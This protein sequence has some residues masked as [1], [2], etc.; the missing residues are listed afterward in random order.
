MGNSNLTE[1]LQLVRDACEADLETYI[2]TIAPH[3]V[4]GDIHK[5][6]ISWW[7]RQDAKDNQL[8]LLPRAHQKS[9]MVA[10][11][12]AWNIVNN[13]SLTVLYVSATADLAEIQLGL[14]KQIFESPV[15]Q[16]LWPDLID[17]DEGKRTRW[18][19]SEII[20]DHPVRKIEAV[21]DPTIKTAGLTKTIT[22]F[23]ADI[24]VLDD[25]VEPQN[26]Y[27]NDGRLQVS[28]LYSQLASIENPG[29]KEWVVGTRYHPKDLYASLLE[30]EELEIGEDGE[31]QSTKQV[32]EVMQKV[33]E[34]DGEFLWPRQ[35]RK[36]GKYYGFNSAV[37]ARIKAKYLDKGQFWAQY[38]NDPSDPDNNNVDPS[39][40]IYYEPK[41]LRWDEGKWWYKNKSLSVFAGMDFAFS[42]KL[43]A[44]YTALVVIGMDND[45]FIYVLDIDRFKTDRISVYFEH[46]FTAYNKWQFRKIRLEVTVAQQAIVRDLKDT[47]IRPNGLPLLV[48]EYR[49]S[50]V[51]GTKEERMNATL[52]P[53]YDT[54]TILHYRGGNCQILEDELIPSKPEHDDI[55]D[56]LTAAIDIAKPPLKL[57]ERGNT[58]NVTYHPRF[59]GITFRTGT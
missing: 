12:V 23:H 44:D 25:V 11:R 59:G 20:V 13:P 21:R 14:I 31:I 32:Y 40:F 43:G 17:V 51:E 53:R 42:Q 4:L 5:E 47:Y 37:L 16:K 28:R 34:I 50:R 10:Y 54:G 30:M 36:D 8:L 2:R 24:V 45:G 55:K 38:Y 58:N 19:Q 9:V 27:T 48:D 41:Y 49:P 1:K 7:T 15:H 39:Q 33:V 18:T 6:V 46:L 35:R 22:G 3:R 29:A 26:A 56:A 52:N 57:V